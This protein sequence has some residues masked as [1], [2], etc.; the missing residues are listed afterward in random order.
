[1]TALTSL[2]IGEARFSFN[3][4]KQLKALPELKKLKIVQTK[5]E[6][7]DI[8]SLKTELPNVEVIF[9]PLTDEQRKRLEG[10]LK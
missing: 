6:L 5:I 2:E 1:M 4:L 9:E 10:Y 7:G 3:A 8:E